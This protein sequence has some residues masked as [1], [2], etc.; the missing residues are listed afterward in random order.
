MTSSPGPSFWERW[1]DFTIRFSRPLLASVGL[2]TFFFA[3]LL[4]RLD[5]GSEIKEF[6]PDEHIRF[7]E[8]L[9]K[10]F[11]E[12]NYLTLIFE[13]QTDKSLVEPEL[14]QHQYRVLQEIKKRYKVTSFSLVDGIDQ[15]LRSSKGKSL[16]E[17]NDYSSIA[18]GIIA[19]SNPRTVRDLEKVSRNLLSHPEAV[20]FYQK[21][22]IA[23]RMNPFVGGGKLEFGAPF[24][25]AARAYL[26]FDSSYTKAE[27]TAASVGIRDLAGSLA[28]TD[29]KV[30]AFSER[31]AFFDVDVHA[32]KNIFFMGIILLGVNGFLLRV[33]FRNKR[34]AVVVFAVLAVSSLWTFALAVLFHIHF[35]FLHLLVLPILLGTGD[36]NSY[37]FGARF[38]EELS[39]GKNFKEA[40][41]AAYAGTGKGIFLTTFTTLVAFLMSGL[42]N[43]S[44]AIA[45]FNL[46]VALSMGVLFL[47]SLI[48]EGALRAELS[49]YGDWNDDR[50]Q[51]PMPRAVRLLEGLAPLGAKLAGKAPRRTLVLCLLIFLASLFSSLKIDAES[52]TRTFL[53]RTMPSYQADRIN[54]EYFGQSDQVGYVLIEGAV[55][56]PAVFEKMKLLEGRMKDYPIVEKIF[57]EAHVESIND[58]LRKNGKPIASD[59]PVKG[60]LDEIYDSGETSNHVLDKSY[61]E[62]A[63]HLIRKREGRYDGLLFKFF[64]NDKGGAEVR[65]FCRSLEEEIRKLGFGTIPGIT[66]RLGGGSVAN[67]I[68]E[69]S[70]VR[71]SALSFFAS[72]LPNFLL[73]LLIWRKGLDSFLAMVP[74]LLSVAT[75]LGIMPLVGVKLNALNLTI[76][77]IVVGLG[78]DYPI[79]IL[80]RFREARQ[81]GSVSPEEALRQVLSSQG[82]GVFGGALSTIAGFCAACILAMPIAESF[83]LLTAF[84]ILA[85]YVFSVLALPDLILLGKR[86]TNR[87]PFSEQSFTSEEKKKYEEMRGLLRLESLKDFYDKMAKFSDEYEGFSFCDEFNEELIRHLEI[88]PDTECLDLACGTGQVAILVAQRASRG[89][90]TAVDLSSGMIEVAREEAIKKG[91]RNVEFLNEDIL[92]YLRR[93]PTESFDL[94]LL[95]FALTYVEGGTVFREMRRVLR[96]DGKIGVATNSLNS[97]VELQ[98]IFFDWVAKNPETAEKYGVVQLP[99]LPASGEDLRVRL[100]EA[101]FSSIEILER[102]KKLEFKSPLD[103]L[104]YLIRSGWITDYF[105][106]FPRFE[107]RCL[108]LDTCLEGMYRLCASGQPSDASFEILLAFTP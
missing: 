56:N 55:E 4:F 82:L 20:H 49:R 76:G 23:A 88:R 103:S 34:T 14:L 79:H 10:D 66:V 77:A 83:G 38:E 102:H 26:Q 22:R 3:V 68:Q 51:G 28:T 91:V 32:R 37:I 31:L 35:S 2:L 24:V 54:E 97:L 63:E 27:Q 78:V 16:L 75:V 61:R 30:Y 67:R 40:L 71:D 48:L 41:R 7:T 62:E 64:V 100:K 108:I 98:P 50:S 89:R 5:Y 53:R 12:G 33:F 25:K 47:L 90:V 85:V 43:P 105:Y 45:S 99:P 94:I 19:L 104:Y 92:A 58:L 46:L 17:E 69:G 42:V 57:G 1:A 65:A 9:E 21:F 101:G 39:K 84:A 6:F 13:T 81:G 87:R 70:Y 59:M 11:K 44:K 8:T 60:I 96:E 74:L 36:D 86:W 73:L 18:A 80:E 52:S 29:L 72:L 93:Q 95:S 15:A 107:E 106:R